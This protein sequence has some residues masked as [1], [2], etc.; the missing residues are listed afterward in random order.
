MR[1]YVVDGDTKKIEYQV[2][3]WSLLGPLFVLLTLC[4]LLFKASSHWAFPFSAIIG[5]PLCIRW[6]TKGMAGALITLFVLTCV[7][8]QSLGLNERYWYVGLS[9]AIA[10][11]LIILTLSL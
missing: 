6:Q 5:V 4:V 2:Q 3:F 1:E 11:S 8:Y 10:F 7:G 9:L